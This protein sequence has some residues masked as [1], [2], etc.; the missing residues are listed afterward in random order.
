RMLR[1][2]IQRHTG[3]NYPL[4]TN[5]AVMIRTAEH[6]ATSKLDIRH[7]RILL[8]QQFRE[9]DYYDSSAV[10]ISVVGR[11]STARYLNDAEVQLSAAPCRGKFT[12]LISS[13]SSFDPDQDTGEKAA[14]ALADAETAGFKALRSETADWW[15][16]FW[17]R[18]FVYMHDPAHQADWV[19][20]NYTYFI[21]L[22]GA[23]SRGDYPPRFGGMLWR[24]TG[25]L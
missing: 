19:E 7:G 11:K 2:A 15:H 10:A 3:R 4:A 14:N 18:G 16:D 8:I 24:T 20:G 13:A 6:T 23:S 5:H 22:M 9:H 21:Y 17:T 12:V 1:Y 25:D